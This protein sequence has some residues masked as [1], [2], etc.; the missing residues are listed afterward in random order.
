MKD[1]QRNDQIGLRPFAKWF[2]EKQLAPVTGYRWRKKGWLRTVNIAG[3]IYIS[4]D[5]IAEFETRAQ[6]GEF[7]RLV[8]FPEK[9]KGLDSVI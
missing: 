7:S 8:N 5:A 4:D 1:S 2:R 3:K 6:N 9:I